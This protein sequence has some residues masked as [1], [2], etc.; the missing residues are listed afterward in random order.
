M[1][2]IWQNLCIEK[3]RTGGT[4]ED[5]F[6]LSPSS[7]KSSPVVIYRLSCFYWKMFLHYICF[8]SLG[9]PHGTAVL[10]GRQEE[11]GPAAHTGS[12]QAMAELLH[13]CRLCAGSPPAALV[14]SRSE[15]VMLPS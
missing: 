6:H 9:V 15:S 5:G 8:Y 12:R 3:K 10:G 2:A 14:A 11:V 13:H 7:Q 1:I 4:N